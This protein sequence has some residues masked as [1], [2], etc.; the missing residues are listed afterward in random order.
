MNKKMI[1]ITRDFPSGGKMKF[2]TRLAA[3]KKP[4]WALYYL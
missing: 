4:Q 2:G 1:I 3:A